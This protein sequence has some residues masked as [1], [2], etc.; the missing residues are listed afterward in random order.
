M[1]YKGK[2]SSH[3]PKQL[4]ES[5]LSKRNFCKNSEHHSSQKT[6]QGTGRYRD[7]SESMSSHL[8]P[9]STILTLQSTL[10]LRRQHSLK[11]MSTLLGDKVFD[12]ISQSLLLQVL[13]K[14]GVP[15][16]MCRTIPNLHTNCTVHIKMVVKVCQVG[17]R[18]MVS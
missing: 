6:T 14:Y 15:P 16:K 7:W 1:L 4:M 13:T 5:H 10:I 12:T 11:C 8:L 17:G 9:R 2:G 18:S 3:K